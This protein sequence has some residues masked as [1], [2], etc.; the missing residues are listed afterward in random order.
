MG[1]RHLRPEVRE[2]TRPSGVNE[3]IEIA[4]VRFNEYEERSS[5]SMTVCELTRA[6]LA[7]IVVSITE[8]LAEN[9]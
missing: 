4:F 9:T 2:I 6:D 5:G 7:A 8:F 1:R 3:G